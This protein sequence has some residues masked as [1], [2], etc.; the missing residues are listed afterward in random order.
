MEQVARTR[1]RPLAS[2]SI[3]PRKAFL[4]L[5]AQ[6]TVG[7]GVLLQLNDYSKVLGASSLFLVATYP[8]MKRVTSWVNPP[9]L[10]PSC[11]RKLCASDLHVSKQT[12]AAF[13][14]RCFITIRFP[15]DVISGLCAGGRDFREQTFLCIILTCACGIVSKDADQAIT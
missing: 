6:S 10:F 3:S 2:K 15:Q 12:N 1:D 9:G 11:F 14:V 5:A 7:L 13:D 8:L 4:F